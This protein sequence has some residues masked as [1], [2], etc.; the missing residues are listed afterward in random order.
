MP[1]DPNND[2]VSGDRPNRI[3]PG[4][5]PASERSVDR[6]FN[7]DDFAAP[8][9]YSFGDSARNILMAPGHHSWDVSVIKQT[10]LS[11]GDIL[12]FRV[13]FFNAFNQVNFERPDTDFG[14][15]VFGKIFGA[16]RAREIEIALKYSF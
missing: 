16:E 5:L 9:P 1:G 3:G 15:S 14:T 4:A 13:E 7:T 10:R 6:W 8:D 11:D 12:E 2:G